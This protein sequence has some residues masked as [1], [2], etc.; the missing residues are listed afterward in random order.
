MIQ[1]TIVEGF[2]PDHTVLVR[3]PNPKAEKSQTS[4]SF[5]NV[6]ERTFPAENP[7]NF[8]LEKGD[9]VE[10]LVDPMDSIKA[11]FMIFILPLI[12]FLAFYGAASLFTSVEGLLY[13]AGVI[14]LC[15]GLGFNGVLRK[16]KGPGRL[17][18]IQKKMTPEGMKEFMKCHDACKA[19]K[20]CG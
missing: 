8:S 15:A 12:V 4:R 6:K 16:L 20:G 7:E 9:M 5:W 2:Q 17:P 11:A 14:G 1:P 10:I 19:C 13:L 3:Y 18:V